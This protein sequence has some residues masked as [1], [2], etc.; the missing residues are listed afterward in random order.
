M[1]SKFLFPKNYPSILFILIVCFIP[2]LTNAQI[3][4]IGQDIDGEAADDYSG[5]SVSMSADGLTVAIGASSND[6]SGVGAIGHVRVFE[7]NS[8]TSIWDQKGQ[9]IDGETEGD[10]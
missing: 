10:I 5:E 9:E 2:V 8:G 4:Q 3:T 7:F 1:T 6:G